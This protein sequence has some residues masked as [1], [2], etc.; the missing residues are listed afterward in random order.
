MKYL[1]PLKKAK[2]LG[3]ARQGTGHWWAQRVSSL[4]LIPLLLWVVYALVALSP[5]NYAGTVHFLSRSVNAV[6]ST[7]LLGSMFYHGYLGIQVVIEDY[8]HCEVSKFSLLVF[9]KLASI[10]AAVASIFAIFSIYFA[11]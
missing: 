1:T 10:F 5:L 7:L 4:A 2:R 9:L 11:G 3:S 6:L 8:I